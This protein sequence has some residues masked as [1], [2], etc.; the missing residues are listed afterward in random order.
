AEAARRIRIRRA[1]LDPV[2][3]AR[4]LEEPGHGELESLPWILE[5]GGDR[6]DDRGILIELLARERTAEGAV[7]ELVQEGADAGVGRGGRCTADQRGAPIGLKRL[8]GDVERGGFVLLGGVRI[9]RQAR[10]ADGGEAVELSVDLEIDVE[11]DR[12]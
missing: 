10:R 9:D 5:R 8:G 11:L 1:E 2:E 7:A 6:F 4:R 12:V 3:E